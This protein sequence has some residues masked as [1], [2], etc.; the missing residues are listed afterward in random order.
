MF[1]RRYLTRQ[2]QAARY[3]KS[4]KTVERWGRDA[5]LNMPPEY[6]F[7]GR[8]HRREDELEAWERSRVGSATPATIDD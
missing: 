2:D 6:D 8:P 3:S 5:T 4:V 1:Q 7:N